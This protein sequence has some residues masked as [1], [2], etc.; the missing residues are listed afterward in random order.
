LACSKT[1]T[2]LSKILIIF[3][4]T[5]RRGEKRG[6]EVG[7]EPNHSTARKSIKWRHLQERMAMANGAFLTAEKL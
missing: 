1:I 4:K 3:Q 5:D 2:K 6:E 7:E